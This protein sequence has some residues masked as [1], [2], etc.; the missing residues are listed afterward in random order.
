M[1]NNSRPAQ[2][3]AARPSGAASAVRPPDAERLAS[4]LEPAVIALGLD[5]EAVRVSSAGRRRLLRITVDADGGVSLDDIEKAS[6]E[7]SAL[8][9]QSAAMGDAPY[10][11]E[12]SSPGVDRPLTEARHWRRAVGRLVTAPVTAGQAAPDEPAP[13][14]HRPQG[15][16]AASVHGRVVSA[17]VRGVTLDTDDG[18]R[19][20]SY[21][22]LGP[23]RVQIEFGRLAE[24][25]GDGA[26]EEEPDGY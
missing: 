9:D 8:L 13:G 20:F 24:G 23:G 6:R 2:P 3:R 18:A 16:T 26:D 25:T 14:Q 10:T 22:E 12:V 11:I 5:L 15:G 19:R 7:L 17:D 4:L 21:G 1:A